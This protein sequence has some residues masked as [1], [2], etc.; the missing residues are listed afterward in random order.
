M[1]PCEKYRFL[2][3]NVEKIKAQNNINYKIE[4]VVVTKY[5]KIEDVIALLKNEKI[6]HIGENRVQEA[7]KK[8]TILSQE[9]LLGN[10]K[11][12]MLGPIQSNKL[13]KVSKMFD[14]VQ[15]IEN[16]DIPLGLLKRNY[17]GEMF[18][19]IKVSD[20]ATKH[21][22]MP[23]AAVDFFGKLLENKIKVSGLM[24]LAPYTSNIVTLS[25]CFSTLR[26]I[27]E[28]IEST[29]KVDLTYLSMGMSNDYEI[30]I[31]EGSNMIRIGSLIFS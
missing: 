3:E 6:E 7:E 8:F 18:L 12:H 4:I 25:K 21:G 17:Q 1:N 24:T 19:E 22:I 16:L 20:E 15:S 29:Y 2:L 27:K 5:A 9:G 28:K 30:A 23:E 11:K 13:S 14:F 31:K 10:T 26:K